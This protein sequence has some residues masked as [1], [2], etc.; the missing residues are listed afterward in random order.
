MEILSALPLGQF[1]V[2]I[3]HRRLL[4]AML[5]IAGVP[6]QKFR[7]ICSAIDKLDKEPWAEVKREMVEDKG[8]EQAVADVIGTFVG[9]RGAPR[10]VLTTLTAPDHPFMQHEEAKVGATFAMCICTDLHVCFSM[11]DTDIC[12]HQGIYV[13]TSRDVC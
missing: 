5:A 8:L 7:P 1:K 13:C 11:Y 3:N 6:A 10:D 2:K 12:G 9:V 4:D